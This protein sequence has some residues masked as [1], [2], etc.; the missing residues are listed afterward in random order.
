LTSFNGTTFLSTDL[1]V[2]I[3]SLPRPES[4]RVKH[5]SAPFLFFSGKFYDLNGK[6]RP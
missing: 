3:A 6:A 1:T 5:N 2:S 4:I